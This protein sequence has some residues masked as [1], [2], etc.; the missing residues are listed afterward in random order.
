MFDLIP[1]V[2]IGSARDGIFSAQESTP[3]TAGNAVI[4]RSSVKRNL[5]LARLGHRKLLLQ[6]TAEVI[7]P[8]VGTLH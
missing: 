8:T 4:E 6:L 3:D 2:F 1:A 7:M 5:K